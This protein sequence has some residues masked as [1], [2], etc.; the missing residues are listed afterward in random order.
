VH[1]NPHPLHILSFWP[2]ETSG[3]AHKGHCSGS[4]VVITLGAGFGI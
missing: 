1:V 4:A 3:D 2:M